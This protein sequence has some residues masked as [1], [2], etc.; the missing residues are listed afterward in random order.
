MLRCLFA[1]PPDGH[2]HHSF[3]PSPHL[4]TQEEVA[5]AGSQVPPVTIP[6][7]ETTPSQP[8]AGGAP[9]VEGGEQRAQAGSLLPE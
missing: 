1:P 2:P 8:P 5:K 7:V 3:S 4:C 6:E 9:A